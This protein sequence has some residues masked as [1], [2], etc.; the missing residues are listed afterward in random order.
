MHIHPDEPYGF[1]WVV[2]SGAD[3]L[4]DCRQEPVGAFQ[5]ALAYFGNAHGQGTSDISLLLQWQSG[6]EALVRPYL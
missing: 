3:S 6:A 4:Q 5:T 1:N 2:K